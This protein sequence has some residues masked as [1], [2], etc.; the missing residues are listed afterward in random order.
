V[1]ADLLPLIPG[2]EGSLVRVAVRR[3]APQLEAQ[4]EL[5]GLERLEARAVLETFQRLAAR[6]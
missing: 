6:L 3:T 5:R 1:T 2:A 4:W